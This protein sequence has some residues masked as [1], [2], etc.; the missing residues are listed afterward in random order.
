MADIRYRFY[1]V[2]PLILPQWAEDQHTDKSL[3]Y[4]DKVLQTT[5]LNDDPLGDA[6]AEGSVA[7]TIAD[8]T[9]RVPVS[10]IRAVWLNDE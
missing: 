9:L 10:N 1:L 8:K 3:S 4:L 2:H 5:P 7:F 6:L